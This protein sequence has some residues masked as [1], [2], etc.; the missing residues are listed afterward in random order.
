MSEEYDQIDE[1]FRR[2][3]EQLED[4]MNRQAAGETEENGGTGEEL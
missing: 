1:I 2:H 3:E 4:S